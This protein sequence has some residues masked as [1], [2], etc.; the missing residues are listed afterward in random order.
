L[1]I[2]PKRKSDR[3]KVIKIG[4]KVIDLSREEK[5][6]IEPGDPNAEDL[7]KILLE[8][9]GKSCE[10]DILE[11]LMGLG[12]SEKIA[13]N[14]FESMKERKLI[15]LSETEPNCYEYVPKLN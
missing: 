15:R 5:P 13:R 14:T 3:K 9:R 6:E 12:Y 7:V 11:M 1:G 10:E 4:S 2:I 8:E